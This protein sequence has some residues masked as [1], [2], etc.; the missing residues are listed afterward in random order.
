MTVITLLLEQLGSRAD[1]ALRMASRCN[2]RSDTSFR[3]DPCGH[4]GYCWAHMVARLSHLFMLA[5]VTMNVIAAV[6]MMTALLAATIAIT[7]TDI[8]R[9]RPIP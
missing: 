3:L 9:V 1:S 4:N 5:P 7:Q 8:K 6:G 2:G